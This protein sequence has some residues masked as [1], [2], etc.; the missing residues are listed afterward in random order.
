MTSGHHTP[1][2]PAG[3][4][5]HLRAEHLT[6]TLGDRRVLTDA[7]VRIN[8]GSRLGIVG[9]NGRGKT[10][11]L[12]ILT[13]RLTP[14][15]GR[16]Q[17]AGTLAFVPQALVARHD[18]DARTSRTVGDLIR[19]ALRGPHAA[20]E[21][22]DAASAA[23]AEHPEDKAAARRYATAL[24]RATLWEAWDAERRID[25][26]LEGLDACSDRDRPLTTLSVGQRYR[27]RLAVTLGSR[28]DLLLLDEPTNHL[29]AV[30]LDFLTH[31]LIEH[32]GGVAVVTHDRALL[33]AVCTHILDLDPHRDGRPH[34]YPGGYEGWVSRRRRER[35][36]WEQE[37]AE[38]VAERERLELAVEE[39]RGQM[40]G[41][42]RPPKGTGKHQRA[43]R[44]AG[45]VQMFNRRFAELEAHEITVPEPPLVL[46]WPFAVMPDGDPRRGGGRAEEPLLVA[47][48]VQV[49]GRLEQ[50]MGAALVPGGRVLV[51]GP[52]GAG[53]STLL[54]VLAGELAPTS[55]SVQVGD[56]VRVRLVSQETPA[57]DEQRSAAAVFD[58]H[59]RRVGADEPQP[60]DELVGEVA[61]GVSDAEADDVVRDAE[62]AEGVAE[63]DARASSPSPAPEPAGPP[64]LATLGLLNDDVAETPVGRL[65]Q[66]QQARL[67]LGMALIERPHVLL[68]DEPTNHLSPA[69]VDEMTEALQVT[70]QA[71]VVVTHD[72]QM[73][74][75][76]ADWPR[77]ELRAGG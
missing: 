32:P 71:V 48:G 31:R 27:V 4:A 34:Q 15:A 70:E 76:L 62:A 38:Q 54:R 56:D 57:W 29:D 73:L 51:T 42:W 24:D 64:T 59:V 63:G 40:Q 5:A 52:N 2:L 66:G 33:R 60:E 1:D 8:A 26:D 25:I 45:I 13:G 44:S 55:G 67:H 20:I 21:E 11:L 77:V 50:P 74:A 7:T 19:E 68:L 36:A 49:A 23:Y 61:A 10:T 75:D 72:R 47:D 37:Y 65:S 58:E 30:A 16:V 43:T 6:I 14:D 9:E 12:H 39:A 46:D 28:P 53:K 17:R 35:A 18:D 69:L 22:L 3:A 41:T